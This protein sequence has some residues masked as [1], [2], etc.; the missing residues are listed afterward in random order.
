MS[1]V[2]STLLV[3][4]ASAASRILGFVRDV[5]FAQV[6]GAGPVADAFLAA[7]RLPTRLR[8]VLAEGG[9]NP[10]LVPVLVRLPPEEGARFAG[11]TIA[12][13]S[14]ALLAL[15]AIVEA[16]AGGAVLLLAPG[17]AD[18]PGTLA[19]AAFYTRL[20]FPLVVGVTLASFLAAILNARR[21][22]LASALAPLAVNAALIAVL[23]LVRHREDLDAGFRGLWLAAAASLSGLV[24]LALLALALLRPGEPIL[25]PLRLRRSPALKG[26]VLTALPVLAAG[27]GSQLLVVVGTQVASFVPSG[28]SWLYYADRVAQLPIGIIASAAGMVLLPE[29]TTRLAAGE[30]GAVVASQNRAL[31]LALLVALPAAAALSCLAHPIAS[32]L[33][34]R[35][36]FGPADAKGTALALTGLAL[37]L[38]PAVV[39]KILS[40][41]LFAGGRTR[42]SLAALGAG[43]AATAAAALLLAGPLGILGIACGIALGNLAQMGVSVLALRRAGLFGPDRSL[44]RRTLRIVAACL[45]LA[46]GLLAGTRL[47]PAD[48][49]GL[50][51]L[52]LGGL[53]LYAAAGWAVGAVT[54]SDLGL[55]T[56]KS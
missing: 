4:A 36:A 10:A 40:Q 16:A 23:L 25:G 50:A 6:L 5:L 7:F 15:T 3:G 46:A 22:F 19:L 8:R 43:L 41:T 51:A 33:F 21:R 37:S 55:L 38:P 9:L 35:G 17:L 28:L 52:C 32:V 13:L 29:L 44:G 56:K 12:A 45:V 42:A 39:V 30:H 47:L 24:Q 49:P 31:E 14:L 18:D 2:R 26:L 53:A 11:E 27:A 54:R 48:A 20:A 1:L 34:E